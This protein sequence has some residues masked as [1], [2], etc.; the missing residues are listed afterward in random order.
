VDTKVSEEFAALIFS[1]ENYGMPG[2]YHP[3]LD[4]GKDQF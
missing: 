2:I 4:F 1:A 3:P